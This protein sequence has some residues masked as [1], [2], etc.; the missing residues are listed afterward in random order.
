MKPFYAGVACGIALTI[1]CVFALAARA[2]QVKP[3]PIK[4]ICQRV[5][6]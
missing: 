3:H 1:L 2:S 5:H 4:P 6:T